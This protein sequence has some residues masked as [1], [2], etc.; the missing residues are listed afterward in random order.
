MENCDNCGKAR[1]LYHDDDSDS[2]LC[3]DCLP[4]SGGFTLDTPQQI[5]LWVLLSRRH[6][7]QLQMKGLKTP[8]LVK[9][10]QNNI[11]GAG[12]TAKDCVVP[13][14]FAISEAG[15]EVDYK[16]VNVQVMEKVR[17]DIFQDLGI[18]SDITE[19]EASGYFRSL[20]ENGRL[21]I[22]LTLDEPRK[23]TGDLLT[24]A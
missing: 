17:S 16:L 24:P 14:E 13:V 5:G 10:C 6:Q 11:P 21:E 18:Y 20:A 4:K 9:W 2:A 23:P 15:G 19:V 7:L 12:R 1:E 3:Q 22:V 8:G